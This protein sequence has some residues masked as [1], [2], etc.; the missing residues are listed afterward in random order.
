[1]DRKAPQRTVFLGNMRHQTEDRRSKILPGRSSIRNV[2]CYRRWAAGI[3]NLGS[4]V[5]RA[6]GCMR[7]A[8]RIRL[9]ARTTKV[10]PSRLTCWIGHPR[11]G[12]AHL[13]DR[14]APLWPGS[15]AGSATPLLGGHDLGRLAGAAHL[16]GWSPS[17]PANLAR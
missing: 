2:G 1:M 6:S 4:W 12:P 17:F 8:T 10:R 11:F 15:L 16:L 13:L 14:P 9:G 5:G 3:L 7:A